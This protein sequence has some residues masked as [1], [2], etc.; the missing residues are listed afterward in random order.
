[1][2]SW[3]HGGVK[4]LAFASVEVPARLQHWSHSCGASTSLHYEPEGDT[5]VITQLGVCPG[6][7]GG[8]SPTGDRASRRVASRGSDA[9]APG[10]AAVR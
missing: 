4:S 2:T 8:S 10:R 9:A 7:P 6:K 3:A 1:M 5:S